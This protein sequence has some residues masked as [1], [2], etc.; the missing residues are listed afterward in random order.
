MN[1]KQTPDIIL[2]EDDESHAEIF[3][4]LFSRQYPQLEITHCTY[5]EDAVTL[6]KTID[7]KPR[8]VIL[9]LCLP[10]MTGINVLKEIKGC[11]CCKDTT[12]VVFSTSDSE[13]DVKKARE[14]GA[15]TYMVK[16]RDFEEFKKTV[17]YL[18]SKFLSE[19]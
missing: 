13:E 16:P 14:Y 9:D 8:L 19:A 5:G 2:V 7:T 18:G 3:T 15:E 4:R 17:M 10:T 6:C 11:S 1:S 12:V